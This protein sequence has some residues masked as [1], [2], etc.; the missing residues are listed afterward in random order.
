MPPREY[1]SFVPL[2]LSLHSGRGV[3]LLVVDGRVGLCTGPF[4]E[5][6]S[7][8][9]LHTYISTSPIRLTL[10]HA[11][12]LVR[13]TSFTATSPSPPPSRADGTSKRAAGRIRFGQ[14]GGSDV[15]DGMGGE[16][17]RAFQGL[18]EAYSA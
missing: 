2:V 14:V 11:Q 7:C 17:G 3:Y 6:V 12:E 10:R 8:K 18:L 5:R 4:T 9:N 13:D 1:Y 16:D 15:F